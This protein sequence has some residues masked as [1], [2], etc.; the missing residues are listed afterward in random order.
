MTEQQFDFSR[1]G[2]I[3]F[4]DDH[5]DDSSVQEAVTKIVQMGMS[6]QF[7]NGKG[8]PPEAIRNVRIVIL[9]LNLLGLDTL[10]QG[11][12]RYYPAAEA[13]KKIA[14]V[15]GPF[16]V[17]MMATEFDNKDPKLLARAYESQYGTKIPGFVATAGLTKTEEL[18]DPSLLGTLIKNELQNNKSL[19]LILLWEVLVDRAKDRA[20][21]DLFR[22]DVENTVLALI[23]S[24]SD[25]YKESAGRE[26][27]ST[28]LRLVSRRVNI[29]SDYEELNRLVTEINRKRFSGTPDLVLIHRRM[30]YTPSGSEP[31][32]TGDIYQTTDQ[33]RFNDYA[34]LLT[35]T[36]DLGQEKA[37][38]LR[39]CLGFPLKTE[40][41]K[42]PEWPP[43]TRDHGVLQKK[44][45]NMPDLE[46]WTERRYFKPDI[47]NKPP[48]RMYP[49]WHFAESDEKEM[50]G[51]CF[52]FDATVTI[53][54]DDLK[55]WKRISRLDSPHIEDMLQ[56]FGS[57]V[58]RLGTPEIN[59]SPVRLTTARSNRP[60][61]K[62]LRNKGE[63]SHHSS[64][65][66]SQTFHSQ[67][68]A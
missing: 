11:D 36:C 37:S 13:L 7:W 57:H 52:D 25:D 54:Q 10:P 58:F 35:P 31:L 50:F 23:N 53:G 68:R 33:A 8:I 29:G 4:V 44:K 38:H 39:L 12:S 42:N 59:K 46:S 63:R 18:E 27:V 26:L 14:D 2:R 51:I 62:A 61:R 66:R 16:L 45:G 40:L 20:L 67:Y 56:K 32:W 55:H 43:Y 21:S 9:D 48:S 22:S 19:D 64:S 3:L 34:I 60:E 41:V 17:I 65:S 24:L 15:T 6:I 30:F 28:L 47:M 1:I 49:V 5:Y